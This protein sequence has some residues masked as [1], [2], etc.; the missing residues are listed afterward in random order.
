MSNQHEWIHIHPLMELCSIWKIKHNKEGQSLI[1]A[2]TSDIQVTFV[3]N[4]IVSVNS[5]QIS[6]VS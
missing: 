5:K 6:L 1:K 3:G 2:L 4:D